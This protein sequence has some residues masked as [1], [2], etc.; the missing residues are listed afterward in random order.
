ERATRTVR[1]A[2]RRARRRAVRAAGRRAGGR[3]ARLRRGPAVRPRPRRRRHGRRRRA[4]LRRPRRLPAGHDVRRRGR[5]P[6]RQPDRRRPVRARR[7]RAPAPAE[8]RELLPARRTAGFPHPA[9]VGRGGPRGRGADPHQPRRRHG[10]SRNPHRHRPLCPRRGRADADVRSDDRPADRREP[11]QP[12]VLEPGR[13]RERRGPRRGTAG[14]ALRGRRRSPDPDRPP[15]GGGHTDGFPDAAPARRAA[16]RGDRAAPVRAGL[17]PRVAAGRR[18]AP[19]RRGVPG[20]RG[21]APRGPGHRPGVRTRP[22]D[23]HRPAE[24][25]VLL[26]KLPRRQ[27]GG[28]RRAGLPAGRRPVPGDPAPARLPE[29]AGVPLDGAAARRDLRDADR[30]PVRHH[31]RRPV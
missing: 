10:L 2:P 29:P 12:R 20:R 30:V 19:G 5:R 28:T 22:G 11:D 6:L 14:R 23:R 24:R 3:R 17:R 9:V 16:A 31:G 13:R 21:A 8:P 4:R 27:R 25:A 26:G 7:R 15:P 18:G 1:L